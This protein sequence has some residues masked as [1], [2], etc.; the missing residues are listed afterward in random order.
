MLVWWVGM[1]SRGLEEW[2]GGCEAGVEEVENWDG[3]LDWSGVC[4]ARLL[5]A[6]GYNFS[7]YDN[8]DKKTK[9]N[10]ENLRHGAAAD[11]VAATAK[12]RPIFA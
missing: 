3:S 7:V 5:P 1:V 2:R 6:T 9:K 4:G 8:D 10:Q 12:C 11:A